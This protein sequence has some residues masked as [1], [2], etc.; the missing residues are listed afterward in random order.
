[1]S[2]TGRELDRQGFRI[3]GILPQCLVG[4]PVGASKIAAPQGMPA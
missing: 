1:M 4:N 2:F 3:L